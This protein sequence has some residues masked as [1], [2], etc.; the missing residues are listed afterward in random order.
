MSRE[1]IF[2]L[3][4]IAVVVFAGLFWWSRRGASGI[5]GGFEAVPAALGGFG[6]FLGPAADASAVEAG[7]EGFIE[8]GGVFRLKVSEPQ[9]T[10]ML[11]GKLHVTARV[12]DAPFTRLKEGDEV[13]VVRARPH[14]DT[15]EYPG[16]QYKYTTT[17]KKLEK[18]KSV[19]ELLKKVGV[20]KVYPGLGAGEAVKLYEQFLPQGAAAAGAIAV[21]LGAPKK[22]V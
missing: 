2:L 22:K 21:T 5:M 3:L 11:E 7:P 18:F 20:D 13:V 10:Q 19:E 14:G 16:G 15:S 17:V 6:G 1:V 4:I 8:G 12:D 9:Y